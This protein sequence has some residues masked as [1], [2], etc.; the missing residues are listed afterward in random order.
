VNDSLIALI[1]ATKRALGITT[2]AG[3]AFCFFI[4]V[5]FIRWGSVGHFAPTSNSTITIAI[6]KYFM[7]SVI[8]CIT[9]KLIVDKSV[10]NLLLHIGDSGS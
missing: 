7:R 4:R 3:V 6:V 5:S 1:V 2:T 9:G 8:H 10:D